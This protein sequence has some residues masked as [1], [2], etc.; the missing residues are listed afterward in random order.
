VRYFTDI[1]LCQNSSK[2]GEHYLVYEAEL[3]NKV[4]EVE[5]HNREHRLWIIALVSAIASVIIALATRS[6]II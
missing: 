4:V 2:S 5:K 6:V 3:Q 1:T